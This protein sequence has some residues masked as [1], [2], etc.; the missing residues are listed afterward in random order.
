M[1]ATEVRGVPADDP[2]DEIPDDPTSDLDRATQRLSVRVERRTYNKP[3][4]IV[5]GFDASSVDVSEV[6]STLKTQLGA[7]GTVDGGTIEVQGDHEDRVPDL[8]R[9]EGFDVE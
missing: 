6:A 9:E 7:G 4:T 2:F 3:V 5:E 1:F 8:L